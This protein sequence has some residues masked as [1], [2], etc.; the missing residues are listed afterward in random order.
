M[1]G[2]ILVAYATHHG[3]TKEVAEKIA[4]LLQEIG[5][6]VEIHAARRI[7]S[8]DGYYA[9]I[10]GAPLYM[11]RW[12]K[13]ARRFLSRFRKSLPALPAAVFAL[14]PMNNDEKEFREARLQLDKALAKFPW[15]TPR[16]IEMFGGKVDPLHFR[17][18]YNFIP[19]LKKLPS[20]DIRDWEAIRGWTEKLPE[21]LG[22]QKPDIQE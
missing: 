15:V 4:A 13:G 17:F 1:S 6:T 11:F 2:K 21:V 22:I 3:S 7:R 10:L 16:I 20:S 12:H 5:F 8:I 9:V 14:G 19:A 18:P